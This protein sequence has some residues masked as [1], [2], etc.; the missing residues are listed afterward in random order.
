MPLNTAAERASA[1]FMLVPSMAPTIFP[2]GTV[3]RN[4][5][6]AVSW[7]YNVISVT[8]LTQAIV[9]TISIFAKLEIDAVIKLFPRIG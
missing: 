8:P 6:I 7:L 3:T 4:D 2:D 9:A 1:S 5:R